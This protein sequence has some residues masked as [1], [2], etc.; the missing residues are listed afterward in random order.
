MRA[1]WLS[2]GIVLAGLLGLL[3]LEGGPPPARAPERAAD[4]STIAARVEVLRAL[5]FR[6][7]PIPQRVSPAVARREGL[8]DL[9]RSYPAARRRADEEV[10]KLLGLIEPDIDLRSISSSV[11]GEGVAGYY[12]PRSRRLRIVSGTTPDALSE[13]V[14]AHEL[15]HALEDQR[16]GLAVSEG[17][18]DDAAL[19]RLALVEG[20]ATLVMQQYVLRYIGAEKALGRLLGSALQA[21][22]DLPKFLQDQLIFPYIGGMQFVQSLVQRGEGSWK[23][24]DLADRVRVPDSTEQVLHPDKWVAVEPPLRVRLDVPLHDDW[25]RVTSGTWGE[26][27]TNQLLGGN[28]A[29]AAAG[30]GGDRY[31]LWQHGTCASAPCRDQDVLVM[32]WRWDESRDAR[33]FDEALSGAPVARGAAV[34]ARGDTVTLVLAPTAALARRVA[35][36]A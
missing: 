28:A 25:R 35:I 2:M 17:E 9:D 15:T 26:W 27:Q 5:K 8:E 24:V 6:S 19:A 20:S 32:R 3:A 31:E 14:L 4:V 23:L 7:R 34:V 16:F 30:W 11:F 10:L 1:V 33:E 13:M 36:S 21:G 18:S 22:P 29:D 12:D